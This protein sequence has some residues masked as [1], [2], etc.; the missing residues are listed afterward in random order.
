MNFDV[1]NNNKFGKLIQKTD[2]NIPIK[3]SNV[4]WNIKILK[5]NMLHSYVEFNAK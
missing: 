1:K 2:R 4:Q 5:R 3:N